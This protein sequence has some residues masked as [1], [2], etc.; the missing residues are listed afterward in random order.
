MS[1]YNETQQEAVEVSIE[2]CKRA[3]AMRDAALKLKSNPAF[4]K[5]I[6]QG[7]FQD[8]AAALVM[9]K[10][11]PNCQDEANQAV[12]NKSIDSIGLF[13]QFLVETIQKGN[14]MEGALEADRKTLEELQEEAGE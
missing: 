14:Q 1:L 13:R 5:L 4:K 12:I 7:F 6:L 8:E 11:D 3:I 10:S 9:K 2:E